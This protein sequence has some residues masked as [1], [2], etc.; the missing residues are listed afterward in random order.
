MHK[1][2][3]LYWSL[4]TFQINYVWERNMGKKKKP[5]H[6]TLREMNNEKQIKFLVKF[7][8]EW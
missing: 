3:N 4:F 5:L 7:M 1:I 8:C 6:Y 2:Q